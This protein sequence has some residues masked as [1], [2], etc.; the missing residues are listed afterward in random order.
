MNDIIY[1]S[2]IFDSFDVIKIV[3]MPGD[4][5]R[6]WLFSSNEMERLITEYHNILSSLLLTF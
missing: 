2:D 1:I 6:Y 3:I 4:H 5:A